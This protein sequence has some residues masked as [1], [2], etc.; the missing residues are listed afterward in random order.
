MAAWHEHGESDHD[1]RPGGADFDG[2]DLPWIGPEHDDFW[3]FEPEEAR[4]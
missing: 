2:P 3:N 4:A 1:A